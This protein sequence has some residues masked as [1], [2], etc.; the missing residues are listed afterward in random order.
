MPMPL[1]NCLREDLLVTRKIDRQTSAKRYFIQDPISQETFE[2][3]EEEYFLCQ[4]MDGVT[5]VPEILASFQERFNISLTEED[6]Q[7]FAGQIDSFGL[8]EPHQNQLPSSQ[9]EEGN[10]HKNSSPTKKKSK[11]HSLLFIWKHP[12]PDAVFTSLARWTHPCHRWLRWSTWLLLPLLPIALLTF[13]N[14][15]TVL[16]Y[17]VGRFVHGLPFVLSYLVDILILNLCG[18]IIQGTVFAAYGGRSSVFGMTLALGF[19]PHFHVDLR[20]YQS[21]PR[22]AQLWIYGTPLIMRLFI[23]SFGMIFWY[24]QR[25]SGTAF[26]IWL[27]LLAHAALATFVLMACPLWP[28]YG[29]YFLIAFFRLPD[30][31]MSQ[32]FRAWGMVIK[33]RNLPSF[34]STR[35]KLMLVGFGLGSIVFCLL[36]IYLI[37][38][39]FAKGLSTLFP[40]IFGPESAIIIVSVLVF[41]GFRKQ[42]SRLFFRGRNSQATTGLSSNLTEETKNSKK[43]SSPSRQGF[44]SWLKKNLKFFILA[45]LVALLFL[46]YRTMPGGPLQLL[47]PAEV[48]IQAEVDGKSK[49]TRVMF[50]GGNEQLIRKGTVIAQMEDV[51]IEDTIET[52]QSQI[53]KALGDVKIK[54]SYLAKLLATP[55]KEDVEVARN[56]VKIAREE[57]DKAKKEVAVNKQNLEVIKKQIESALTQADFYFREASR[58]EEGYKEGAIALNLVEDAQRNAQTKKIEAEEKR[59]AL[60]QQQQ[61]IEQARSQLASKQRVLETSESQLKL[62]LAGPYPDEIEAARQ[63]VEVAG[64]EL[65][66]LRKQEQ[67]ERD[68]LKLTTLVMPLDGYLVTP[69]LDTKVGSYLDQG[70][71]FA[72]AQDATKIL[73]EV[74]VPEYDVGQFSIGKKVQIKLNAYPTE[75]I[76]GKVVSIT[77]SADNSTTTGDLSSE[78]V[79]KVLVEIPDGKHLFKTGM[80]GYAKIE[81]PMKPFIVAFSSPIVRFFQIEIWSWLP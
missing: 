26:H 51:D 19:K 61:V 39:N 18:R 16:W 3:G 6:Y 11:Q 33:G 14:N 77:P 23:F 80:T 53:E 45:G 57:V 55:R 25:S 31:F 29:Y 79:V 68:K 28:L 46:P 35:E 65:E 49:I 20:E 41:I 10:G 15:R 38:T 12:N 47:T 70:E 8:L 69:Y 56:Q 27:L 22:K 36:M 17:D 52:L 64:A 66:R 42:I 21:V 34:L 30:N 74:Q 62:L 5:S 54:Q 58:L 37:V 43:S 78:P 67:Q 32:S 2:F 50:S 1:S 63:D 44:R 9:S 75:T 24:A 72:T 7:K 60:L 40:E 71:T 81:G 59:Q 48:A 4:L 76:M 13:W 73:A